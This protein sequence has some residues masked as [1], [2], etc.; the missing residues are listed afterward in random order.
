MEK[1]LKNAYSVALIQIIPLCRI[2]LE[3][4]GAMEIL[5]SD[6]TQRFITTHIKSQRFTLS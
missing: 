3:K 6:G 4:L 5:S 1:F 2:F